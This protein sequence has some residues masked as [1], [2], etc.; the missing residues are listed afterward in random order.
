ME[1]PGPA[2]TAEGDTLP[3][4]S[5]QV[6]PPG[7]ALPPPEPPEADGAAPQPAGRAWRFVYRPRW[8]AWHLFAFAVALGMLWLGDWQYRRAL[9][10]NG[11]SWA[12]TFEWPLFAGF[13]LVFWARTIRDEYRQRRHGG[14]SETELGRRAAAALSLAALPEGAM[15]PAGEL[16][17]G[18]TVRELQ[19]SLRAAQEAAYDDADDPELARYNAHLAK[20]NARERRK[21]LGAGKDRIL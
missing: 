5:G 1:T 15:L 7:S 3:L 20:L 4:L 16:P 10:G 6:V 11:L 14:L 13:A 8:V 19:L 12:Y 17:A 9:G 2:P 21:A 18:M